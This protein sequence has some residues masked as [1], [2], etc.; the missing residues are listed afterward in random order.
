[1]KETI[2]IRNSKNEMLEV[3]VSYP[4][5]KDPEGVIIFVHGFGSNLHENFHLFDDMVKVLHKDYRCIQFSFSGYGGS[6]GNQEDVTLE[7]MKDDLK[8]IIRYATIGDRPY[9]VIAHSLGAL[10][11]SKTIDPY[12]CKRI[13]LTSPSQIN[14]METLSGIQKRIIASGGDLNESGISTYPRT[15]GEVQKIGPLFWEKF[16]TWNFARRLRLIKRQLRDSLKVIIPKDDEVVKQDGLSFF[17]YEKINHVVLDG[18]HN[19]S[20]SKDRALLILV[21]KFFQ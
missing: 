20:K 14:P 11:A 18:D 2:G 17:K 16:R 5:E 21:V 10:V 6:E 8:A 7:K 4:N 12:K 3:V 19:F 15:S 13:L 1:M 9:S